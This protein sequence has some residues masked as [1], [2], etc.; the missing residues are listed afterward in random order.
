MS[1]TSYYPMDL[2]ESPSPQNLSQ[3][4]TAA[5]PTM[6]TVTPTGPMVR[7]TVE[8]MM[9]YRTAMGEYRRSSLALQNDMHALMRARRRREYRRNITGVDTAMYKVNKWLSNQSG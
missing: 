5:R 8:G 3:K 1:L 6:T 4:S 7:R 2:A 9:T